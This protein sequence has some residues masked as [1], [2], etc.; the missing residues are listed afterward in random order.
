VF[1]VDV[2]NYKGKVET[3]DRGGFFSTDDRLYVGGRRPPRHG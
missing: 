3:R 1:V 2:K